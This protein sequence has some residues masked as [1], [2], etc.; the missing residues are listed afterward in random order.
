[1][2]DLASTAGHYKDVSEQ[3]IPIHLWRE[4][5]VWYFELELQISI[6]YTVISIIQLHNYTF[7]QLYSCTI[8]QLCNYTLYNYTNMTEFIKK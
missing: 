6:D 7:I 1:M 8:I 2:V 5:Q 3:P 4:W